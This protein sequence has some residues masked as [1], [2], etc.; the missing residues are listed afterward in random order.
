VIGVDVFRLGRVVTLKRASFSYAHF[1]GP[2]YSPSEEGKSGELLRSKL[3]SELVDPDEDSA[4]V[5]H[6][7]EREDEE[8]GMNL[9]GILWHLCHG[10][11]CSS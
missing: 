5:G 4:G 6:R 11:P 2:G 7:G 8:A 10:E 9:G 1:C 3:S